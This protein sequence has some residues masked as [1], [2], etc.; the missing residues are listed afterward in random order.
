[1]IGSAGLRVLTEQGRRL[2]DAGRQLRVV[3]SPAS[4]AGNVLAISGVDM[5]LDVRPH[6]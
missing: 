3:A 6:P 5:L 1:V 4:P 2:R